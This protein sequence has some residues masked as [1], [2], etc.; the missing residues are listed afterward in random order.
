MKHMFVHFRARRGIVLYA[1]VTVIIL[2]HSSRMMHSMDVMDSGTVNIAK[3]AGNLNSD[4]ALG[5][6]ESFRP[7]PTKNN[8]NHYWPQWRGPLGVGVAPHAVPPIRWSEDQN[9]RWKLALQGK[10]HSTPVVW[11]D[12]V[13][14]TASVA[15]RNAQAIAADRRLGAHDNIKAV[16]C[17]KFLVMAINRH[18]GHLFWEKTVRENTPHEGGHYTGSYASASPVTDGERVYAFFGSHGIYCLSWSGVLLWQKDLGDMHTRHGHGEGSSPALYKNKL[19]IN[20]DHEG[21]SF[22]VALDKRTGEQRWKRM[23]DEASSWSTPIVVEHKNRVQVIISAAKRIRGYDLTT[24]DVIWECGGLSNNVVS[25]PASAGGMVYAGSSYEK[26]A[27]LGIRLDGA[28]GDITGS[29]Q[30]L[31]QINRHTPYVPSLLLY[32]DKLYFL[33]HYQGILSCLNVKNGQMLYGPVRLPNIY[34]VYA[35][36][37]GAAG[38]LYITSQSGVTLVLAQGLT[39]KVLAAN[40]LDDSFSASAALVGGDLFLRGHRYLYCIAKK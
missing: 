5:K 11:D 17:Q 26:R 38:R 19:I 27:M 37:V 25:S 35:S 32:D 30:V 4:V 1:V 29:D 12:H 31:W 6:L 40:Q 8:A 22:V 20:W 9:I 13:F 21:K 7:D 34:N 2:S 14:V 23:R 24:G 28:A 39:P 15:L 16:Q 10:G 36:P 3:N 33:K 18:T